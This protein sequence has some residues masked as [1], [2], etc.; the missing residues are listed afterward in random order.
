MRNQR[1][2]RLC[3]LVA[4]LVGVLGIAFYLRSTRDGG[5]AAH[6]GF[7]EAK[8]DEPAYRPDA[9]ADELLTLARRTADEL[10]EAYPDDP[11]TWSVQARR[12]YLLSETQPASDLWR[13]SL[14]LDSNFAEAFFG[15]GLVAL[16]NDEHERAVERFEDVAR[17]APDDPRVPVLLAKSLMLAGR[18]DDAILIIEKHL[19]TQRTSA[20]AWEMAGKAHLQ[21]Q[22]FARAKAAF[23]VAVQA[24]PNMKEAL[25]GLSRAHAGLGESEK[26]AQYAE[27]FRQLAETSHAEN[28]QSAKLFE[29]RDFAAHVAAQAH[30]DAAR[31]YAR[32]GNVQRSEDLLLRAVRLEPTSV[33]FLAQLQQSLQQRGAQAHAAEVGERIVSLAPEQI[34]HWLNLGWLYSHVNQPEKAIAACRKAIELNP[35]DPRCRQAYEII[36]RFQ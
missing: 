10:A 16:D 3:V 28:A 31:V 1:W 12:H 27:K 15:L 4:L 13:K 30:A 8:I 2:A 18:T 14:A 26:A 35:H 6:S 24:V 36:Q 7:L 23:E 32:Q 5:G 17:L 33:E 19:S 25:Y 22:D 11:G 34:D 21:A 29:D 20:E 9:T